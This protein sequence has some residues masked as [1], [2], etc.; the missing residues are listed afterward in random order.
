MQSVY[1]SR[2]P[3]FFPVLAYDIGKRDLGLVSRTTQLGDDEDLVRWALR[4]K[5]VD[6]S[7][8][9]TSSLS[10]LSHPDQRPMVGDERYGQMFRRAAGL[11]SDN[12]REDAKVDSP[13]RFWRV[14][15][16]LLRD[17]PDA[18]PE[19]NVAEAYDYWCRLRTDR[20]VTVPVALR[21][22]EIKAL[23]SCL[24]RF[25]PDLMTSEVDQADIPSFE[26]AWQPEVSTVFRPKIERAK[27]QHVVNQVAHYAFGDG[28]TPSS[29]PCSYEDMAL[30]VLVHEMNSTKEKLS[31]EYGGVYDLGDTFSDL[32]ELV[33]QNQYTIAHDEAYALEQ[34]ATN[35]GYLHVADG[36]WAV[37]RPED[38]LH[39]EVLRDELSQIKRACDD[40]KVHQV[41]KVYDKGDGSGMQSG[42]ARI[43][44][45]LTTH[46][47]FVRR[48]CFY[49]HLLLRLRLKAGLPR[50]HN[51][52]VSLHLAG[53]ARFVRVI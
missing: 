25:L 2:S 29:P 11:P 28:G 1:L 51:R 34:K 15:R 50:V 20:D 12:V 18:D 37:L 48:S 42:F 7:T 4:D 49:W 40:G 24:D 21:D 45:W 13:S 47:A 27:L 30:A 23:I 53:R 10:L 33:V 9:D 3:F 39:I 43:V 14:Y 19:T 35:R 8:L 52:V 46:K 16:S 41:V 38:A 32:H 26:L 36:F 44:K 22:K 6:T 5:G 17:K 31:W